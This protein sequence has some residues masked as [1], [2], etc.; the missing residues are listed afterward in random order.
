MPRAYEDEGAYEGK[1]MIEK[2][3]TTEKMRKKGPTKV[4]MKGI[5]SQKILLRKY[6]E[7]ALGLREPSSGPVK[8]AWASGGGKEGL[9]LPLFWQAKAGKNSIFMDF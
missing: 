8:G 6:Q 7:S 1:K 3:P 9:L 2:G 5:N 4:K